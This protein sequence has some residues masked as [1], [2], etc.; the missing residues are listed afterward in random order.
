MYKWGL[1]VSEVRGIWNCGYDS[2][3]SGVPAPGLSEEVF[4]GTRVGRL[5][6]KNK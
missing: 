5:G 4:L 3:A 1:T 2:N 6:L